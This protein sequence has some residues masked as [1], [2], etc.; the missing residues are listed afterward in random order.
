MMCQNWVL[1]SLLIYFLVICHV[2]AYDDDPDYHCG[3]G[4][5]TKRLS[6]LISF[7]CE[8]DLCKFSRLVY[9]KVTNSQ[10]FLTREK[11][12]FIHL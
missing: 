5:I 1:F 6:R 11:L 4:K 7:G 3:M 10:F 9:L 2:A 8:T 12:G